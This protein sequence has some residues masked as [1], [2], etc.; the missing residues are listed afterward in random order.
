MFLRFARVQL[1]PRQHGAHT[2]SCEME[3]TCDALGCDPVS[4]DKGVLAAESKGGCG[5]PGCNM[6]LW[7]GFGLD[8]G[9]FVP[10]D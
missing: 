8:G 10:P 2:R 7:P 3:A 4:P 9:Q 1:W 6:L 5:H